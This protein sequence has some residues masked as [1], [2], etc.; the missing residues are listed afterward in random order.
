MLAVIV[1]LRRIRGQRRRPFV[2]A[3]LLI[4]A[5]AALIAI[6]L[7]IVKSQT[8]EPW[9]GSSSALETVSGKMLGVCGRSPHRDCVMDG[10]T[11]FIGTR[12]IRI[13]DID[14]PETHPSRCDREERLGG[15]ATKRLRALLNL[16]PFELLRSGR[17]EDRY[18]RKLRVVMRSGRSVSEVLIA[19][20]LAR[21]W[22]GRRAPWCP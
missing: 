21:A 5:I 17:D 13:A 1:D 19:E 9:L 8:S 12:P 11:F 4:A 3:L 6:G 18:G 14:A 20:G 22:S 15:A 16:G 10:D 7:L 2:R